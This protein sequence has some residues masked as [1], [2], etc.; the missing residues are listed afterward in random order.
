MVNQKF[1]VNLVGSKLSQRLRP[2]LASNVFAKG[3][4]WFKGVFGKHPPKPTL[5]ALILKEN[6]F[7]RNMAFKKQHFCLLQMPNPY[8]KLHFIYKKEKKNVLALF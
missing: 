4:L 7:L 1:Q 5:T 6:E 2:C 3:F 8:K